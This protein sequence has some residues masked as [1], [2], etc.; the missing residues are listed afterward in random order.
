MPALTPPTGPD[1]PVA[2]WL[3]AH[4]R[5]GVTGVPCPPEAH[6]AA[7]VRDTAI[8]HG[9]HALL[10]R[11]WSRT[12]T[13]ETVAPDLR[14]AMAGAARD[15]AV[16]ELLQRGELARVVDR[17]AAAGVPALLMKGAA[18]S[19]TCYPSPDLRPKSDIDVLVRA[20]D[21]E[22]A[23]HVLAGLD[24]RRTLG[25]DG[26]LVSYQQSWLYRDRHGITH[27]VDLHW[28]L[29]N[30]QVFARVLDTD[31]LF[32]RSREIDAI[33]PGARALG[34]THALLLACM[35][36]VAH[37]TGEARLIWLYD[38]HLLA[39]AMDEAHA[40]AAA[41][42]AVARGLSGVCGACLS[43]ARRLF[44]TRLSPALADLA[45]RPRRDEP[46]A[47]YL[48]APGPLRRLVA[49]LRALPDTGSRALLLRELVFP[50]RTY[51]QARYRDSRK[52]MLPWLYLRR[53]LGGTL[54]A[55]ARGRGQ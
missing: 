8:A 18:L 22:R 39:G 38:V 55:L 21:V 54:A 43:D 45:E 44:H 52:L 46:T 34:D 2:E 19:C 51:M 33:G 20:Q 49:D 3:A 28:R 10:H 29:S 7:R 1:T 48:R 5:D 41:E 35:H 32:D 16:L 24:Y 25:M 9:V 27:C 40:Q 30:P 4:L 53:A 31:E 12:P 6:D 11:A 15:Q 23:G 36:R 50:P 13:A 42:L 26:Q 47:L 17:L 37:H 14:A